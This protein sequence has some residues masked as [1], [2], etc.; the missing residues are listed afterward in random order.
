MN[1]RK[2]VR[3]TLPPGTNRYAALDLWVRAAEDEGWSDAEVQH[4]IDE[5]VE[6]ETDAAGLEVLAWYTFR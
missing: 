1:I 2:K 4:V 6:A 5:V 3:W